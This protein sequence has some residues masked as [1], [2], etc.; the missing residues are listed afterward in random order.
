M[1]SSGV[2]VLI[3]IS[4]VVLHCNGAPAINT[5]SKEQYTT[6]Q[7]GWS[8]TQ[9]TSLVGSSGNVVRSYIE[10]NTTVII[11][12][13]TR[14]TP[15]TTV[16]TFGFVD[17]KLISKSEVGVDS[18][19]TN[20]ITFHQ[21]RT[22]QTKWTQQQVT[23]LLGGP[24]NIVLQSGTPGSPY[25][26]TIVQYFGT[27]SSTA[28]ASFRFVGASLSSKTQA[29]LD[30]GIYTIT[31]Q[32]YTTIQLGW[33]RE[34][35]ANLVGSFGNVASEAVTNNLPTD[36]VNYIGFG[37]VFAYATFGFVGQKLTSKSEVG[38]DLP[39]ANKVTLQQYK[40]VQI[41][42]N[43][44][45]LVQLL[46]GA[47]NTVSQSGTPGSPYQVT[48]VQYLGA[49]SS[50]TIASFT[51][52][53]ASLFSKAQIGL[54]TGIYTITPQQY[55]MIEVG[56]TREQVTNLVGSAGSAVS[57]AGT[58][59][60]GAIIIQYSG[61]GTTYGSATLGFV[62][63]KLITKSEVGLYPLVSNKI[64]LQQYKTIQI[65]WTQQQVTQLL[66]GT[67]NTVSQSGTAGSPYQVTMV[68]YFGSQSSTAVA[69]FAFI[70]GLLSSKAQ[71]GLDTAVY[72]I[73]KQQYTTIDIG[74]T[75]EQVTNLVG[76]VGNAASEAGTGS[77]T[78]VF[79]QYVVPE[80]AYGLV[81][82]GFVGGKLT[83]KSKIGFK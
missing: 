34:Q 29:G 28:I 37:T 7:I 26:V 53:G 5:I 56:W 65:G 60:T 36:I 11:V 61:S 18:P 83:T 42:C 68:Q 38:F 48:M 23:E 44:L 19:V 2:F 27:Q 9:V 77:A 64:T 73:T 70:G 32:Q 22:I 69:S 13:Y 72:T 50:T 39:I 82:F 54:D 10:S 30:T 24:G 62:G 75:R 12:Q 66:G 71:V 46:G 67:G 4:T 78:V 15:S 3:V 6:I 16:V 74:W 17:G 52:V 31:K 57:E 80:A 76:S 1:V 47:G 21:Y 79:V 25:Q 45:Q 49:Q 43:V 63:G 35:V 33:T 51:F 40:A 14:P 81:A 59:N 55:E 20:K 58:G 8:R 41:G